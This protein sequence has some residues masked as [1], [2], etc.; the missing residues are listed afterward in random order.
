MILSDILLTCCSSAHHF[1]LVA[2]TEGTDV[3][4]LSRLVGSSG[5]GG[6][7][8]EERRRGGMARLTVVK[9]FAQEQH[10]PQMADIA[11]GQT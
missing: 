9:P 2:E 3:L 6:A 4:G 11:A 1:P 5:W 7:D 10:V 8:V